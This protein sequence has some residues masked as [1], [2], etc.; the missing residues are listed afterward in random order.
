MK[1]DLHVHTTL[2]DGSLGMEEVIAQA[3]RIGLDFISITD[4]DTMSSVSRAKVLGERYG[5][6]T[7]PGVELT[8]WDKTR[9]RKVHILC[10]APQKPD[11]LEGICRRCSEIRQS[12]AKETV[13][14]VLKLYPITAEDITKHLSGS[15]SIY[16]QHI[17][18]A[19]IEYGYSTHF[20]GKLND[21]LFN[22]KTGSCI[23][24]R[25]Y[26]DVNYVLEL[27]HSARGAAVLAHPMVYD[28]VDLIDDLASNGK[29]DGIEV[30]HYSADEE[31]QAMLLAKANEYDLIVTGGS[32]FHGL[33]NMRPTHLGMYTTDKDNIDRILRLCSKK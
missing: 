21:E 27:I 2:S 26:P 20:Y 22:E 24:E 14:N 15:K 25:E 10:Y 17:L 30:Y 32:D 29:L 28:S 19:L 33:Y 7:I 16:K 4:H 1:G 5:V 31:Q 11:R 23:V 18:H 8:A 3:K 12:C 6:Q 9:N 13:E